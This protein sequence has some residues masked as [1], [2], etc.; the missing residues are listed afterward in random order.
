[1]K[2]HKVQTWPAATEAARQYRA[3]FDA[4]HEGACIL[5]RLPTAPDA[6]RNYRCLAMN[7]AM[8]RMFGMADLSGETIRDH[9][10]D[11]MEE[12]YDD[13]DRVLDTGRQA[14]IERETTGRGMM[15]EL[16]LSRL[17]HAPDQLL[18]VIHDVTLQHRAR[19]ALHRAEARAKALLRVSSGI[20][21]RMSP[22]WTEL[23]QLDGRGFLADTVRPNPRWLDDYIFVE[24]QPQVWTAI[25]EAIGKGGTFEFEHRVRRADGSEGWTSSRAVPQFDEQGRI[26][27]WFGMASDVTGRVQARRRAENAQAHQQMLAEELSH[28][29]KNLLALVQSISSQ[30][31]RNADSL[32]DA[33]TKLSAR[34][35]ALAHA[36][37]G[38]T[39]TAWKEG[40]LHDVVRAGLASVAGFGRRIAIDGPQV[41]VDSRSALSIT[42]AVHE[43]ATNATKYGALSNDNGTVTLS[44]DVAEQADG[45]R[46]VLEWREDGGPEVRE[47][48]SRGFGTRMIDRALR[49]QFS[50]EVMLAYPPEGVT[51][52]IDT[53]LKDL[54]G[55][56]G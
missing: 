6:P 31:L 52:R 16:S 20:I 26:V 12:W 54:A 43:L 24:D 37:D 23:R 3:A 2:E 15:H 13:Y 48:A 21:Y 18:V 30:T 10:P 36:A 1:M 34:I 42:L 7:P 11:E 40:S 56:G 27:E 38:L 17:D 19:E 5:Q 49:T 22:D 51:F 50:G 47:P 4:L 29:L 44:W 25:Q 53:P 39:S 33:S 28:R 46:F 32:A 8:M 35:L 41:T 55:T 45:P 9:F 14:R